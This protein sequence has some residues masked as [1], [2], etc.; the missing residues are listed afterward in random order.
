MLKQGLSRIARV[1]WLL[2]LAFLTAFS[3]CVGYER[4]YARNSGRVVQSVRYEEPEQYVYY[5][6][7]QVYYGSRSHQYYYQDGSSWVARPAPAHISVNVL[8]SSP[9]VPMDFHDNPAA[10]H[11]QVI[12][13]YPKT[14]TQSRRDD[15]HN[16]KTNRDRRDDKRDDDKRQDSR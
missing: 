2:P 10:H 7:Y 4:P 15:G 8:L 11:A 6:G 5:P 1:P 9:S 13:T 16:A 14:W 3:G 12:R